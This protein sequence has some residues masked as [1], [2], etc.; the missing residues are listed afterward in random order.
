MLTLFPFIAAACL[1]LPPPPLYC[2]GSNSLISAKVED[3]FKICC[4]SSLLLLLEM[5]RISHSCSAT[6][7]FHR[8]K[9]TITTVVS[10]FIIGLPILTS[11]FLC[12]R[13]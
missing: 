7:A 2:G 8:A 10:F 4:R 5:R 6:L 1:H 13:A 3:T 11:G 12:A 9:P